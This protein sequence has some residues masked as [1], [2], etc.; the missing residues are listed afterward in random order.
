TKMGTGQVRKL[1]QAADALRQEAA[2]AELTVPEI[3]MWLISTGGFTGEVL[4]YVKDRS[5]IF[6]SDY[7]GIN[8]IFGMYGGNYRIPVFKKD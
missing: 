4:E 5:D 7:E 2:D 3:Q 8:G 1:E 6:F